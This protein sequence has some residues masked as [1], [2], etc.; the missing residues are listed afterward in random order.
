[1]QNNTKGLTQWNSS[2][3]NDNELEIKPDLHTESSIRYNSEIKANTPSQDFIDRNTR[4]NE[5]EPLL[6]S[7]PYLLNKSDNTETSKFSNT[8]KRQQ[9]SKEDIDEEP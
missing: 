4:D 1:M 9:E 5:K 8:T 6:S 7:D 2:K 3:D